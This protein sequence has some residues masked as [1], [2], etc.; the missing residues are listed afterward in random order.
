MARLFPDVVGQL[1]SCIFIEL[2]V[3]GFV[4]KFYSNLESGTKSTFVTLFV[5]LYVSCDY[6]SFYLAPYG[7]FNPLSHAQANS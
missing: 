4:H 6:I 7:D 3:I 5:A 2:D 1:N